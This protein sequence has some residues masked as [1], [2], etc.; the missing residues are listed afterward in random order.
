LKPETS[1]KASPLTR[2][3]GL[4][5]FLR[6]LHAAHRAGIEHWIVVSGREREDLLEAIEKAKAQGLLS[7]IIWIDADL[8]VEEDP[9]TVKTL[10]RAVTGRVLIAGPTA[11]F[12]QTAVEE[13]TKAAFRAP[14]AAWVFS[15]AAGLAIL[16]ASLSEGER[17]VEILR[18]GIPKEIIREAPVT[19]GTCLKINEKK[20]VDEAEIRLLRNT[21]N[22]LDGY[23][24]RHVNRKLSEPISRLFLRTDITPNGITLLTF[25]AGLLSALLFLFPGYLLGLLGTALYQFSSVLDCCDGAVARLKFKESSFGRWL[26][27]TCDTVVFLALFL[28]IGW[29]HGTGAGGGWGTLAGTLALGTTGS[30]L[31]V[32]YVSVNARRSPAMARVDRRI[33]MIAPRDFSGVLLLFALAGKLRWLIFGVAVSANLFWL[34]FLGMILWESSRD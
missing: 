17:L 4:P 13:L 25:F 8:L 23:L 5:L 26:D 29:S 10:Y 32:S 34:L 11:L 28:A 30:F 24:D 7:K 33:G 21:G 20:T 27:D 31:V 1:F 9:R 2:V 6:A 12:D 19:R 16:P 22:A 14:D 15:G 3:G 18:A